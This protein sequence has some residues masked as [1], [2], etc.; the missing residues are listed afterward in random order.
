M[1][2]IEEKRGPA[3]V[4]ATMQRGLRMGVRRVVGRVSI[5]KEVFCSL[6]AVF[7]VSGSGRG[8]LEQFAAEQARIRASLLV[9]RIAFFSELVFGPRGVGRR[10]QFKSSAA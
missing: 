5:C 6:A 2:L 1:S 4:V 10:G 3:G 8:F 9:S 7:V